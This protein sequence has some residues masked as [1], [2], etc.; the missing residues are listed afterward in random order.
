M[1]VGV[2]TAALIG[3]IATAAANTGSSIYSTER[4][5]YHSSEEAQKQRN[6]EERMASTQYQ[7]AVADMEAAGLNPA[8]IGQG[9]TSNAVPSSAAATGNY[10]HAA[11]FSN[12][13]SS[14]VAAA[15]AKDKNMSRE[16]VQQ[17]RNESAEQVQLLRNQGYKELE[18]YK[19]LN[20]HSSY[21]VQA[22]QRRADALAKMYAAK[23]AKK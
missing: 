3:G 5:I 1:P 23:M 11:D 4:N 8:A 17:M 15:M 7:R 10:G 21:A 9:M 12:I 20:Q 14:A 19:K 2:G 22:S 13:F 16:V 6:F 18:G